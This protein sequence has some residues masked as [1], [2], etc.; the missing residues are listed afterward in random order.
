MLR[1]IIK[2]T[3]FIFSLFCIFSFEHAFASSWRIKVNE[4]AIVENPI[5][6]LGDIA[7]PLGNITPSEWAQLKDIQLFAAPEKEGKA[8]QISEKKLK[9]SLEYVLGESASYLLLPNSLAIQKNGALLREDEIMRTIQ[10]SLQPYMAQLDGESELTDY[11]VPKFIF[12]PTKGQTV[13]VEVDKK[14]VEAGRISL[15]LNI[16][17]LDGSIVKKMTASVFLNLWKNVPSP[18]RPYNK[19]DRLDLDEITYLRKNL[20]HIN[21]DVWDGKGGP[22]QINKSIGINEAIL[23]TDLSPLAMIRKGQLVDIKYQKGSV[24]IVQQG[25]ALEDAGPGDIIKLRNTQSKKQV[26]GTVI[27]NKTVLIQ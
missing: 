12:M 27:D 1:N 22:W 17:E 16:K 15:K 21:G 7:E 26:F 24:T 14:D 8:Y 2:N 25:E 20:A 11:R 5:V 18:T 9:E 23:R 19:G 10:T 13:E 4:A 3:L 6:T